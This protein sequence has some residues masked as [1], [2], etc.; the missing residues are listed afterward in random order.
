MLGSYPGHFDFILYDGRKRKYVIHL[1][2]QYV[3]GSYW[4]HLTRSFVVWRGHGWKKGDITHNPCALRLVCSCCQAT[5]NQTVRMKQV[6]FSDL[7][8]LQWTHLRWSPPRRPL[9]SDRGCSRRLRPSHSTGTHR[10]PSCS[11]ARPIPTCRRLLF[12][13]RS[14]P[15]LLGSRW[16]YV[17]A[18]GPPERTKRRAEHRGSASGGTARTDWWRLDG[19]GPGSVS[20][21]WSW[22]PAGR[23]A[24]GHLTLDQ[25]WSVMNRGRRFHSCTWSAAVHPSAE[26][27]KRA[28]R[29]E[30]KVL[31]Y[32]KHRSWGPMMD[33]NPEPWNG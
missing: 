6:K 10:T 7:R 15:E 26:E 2:I 24:T 20:W 16:N 30:T 4:R 5:V 11:P 22:P 21:W 33:I 18:D 17:D 8:P 32:Q 27:G 25:I 1:Y 3:N 31:I 19:A 13:P 9:R 23:C 12:A 14:A 29:E 28:T